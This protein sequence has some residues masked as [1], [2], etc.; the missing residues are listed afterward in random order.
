MWKQRCSCTTLILRLV[1]GYL[2]SS[3]RKA[4]KFVSYSL[5]ALSLGSS[6]GMSAEWERHSHHYLPYSVFFSI[7]FSLLFCRLYCYITSFH[8]ICQ[9]SRSTVRLTACP[10][11]YATK[12]LC[13][14]EWY[15][16]L[17]QWTVL[18]RYE[19][20]TMLFTMWTTVLNNCITD[21]QRRTS[22]CE[23]RKPSLYNRK[24]PAR[25]S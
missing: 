19:P 14:Q 10:T 6:P 21:S 15:F 9:F 20:I 5:E 12:Q 17:C 23:T 11:S 8:C 1:P 16:S 3:V 13:E 4:P 24:G 18:E 22:A 25:H 2:M 7:A